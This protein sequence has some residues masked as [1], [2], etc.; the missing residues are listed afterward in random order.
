M[1]TSAMSLFSATVSFM[2]KTANV[3]SINCRMVTTA[4]QYCA[5][6]TAETECYERQRVLLMRAQ[7]HVCGTVSTGGF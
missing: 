5:S 3:T 4:C 1:Q 2:C 6:H 7:L